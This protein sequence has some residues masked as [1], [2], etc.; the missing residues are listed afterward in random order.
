MVI[1]VINQHGITILEG[2]GGAP[3][4]IDPNRPMLIQS[5]VQSV[6][7]PFWK[8]HV[9]FD[10]KLKAVFPDRVLTAAEFLSS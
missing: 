8:I 9:R 10:K 2:E 7:P 3:V 6:Q 5:A 1:L 4:P